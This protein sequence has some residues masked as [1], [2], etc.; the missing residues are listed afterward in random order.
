MKMDKTTRQV[1]QWGLAL[2][3]V[4]L[5]FS[6]GAPAAAATTV[7]GGDV[8]GTWTAANSPYLI[9]ASANHRSWRRSDLP[10]LV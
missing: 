9:D 8:S 3:L 10:E 5:V 7:V 4:A 2:L 1:S 6:R